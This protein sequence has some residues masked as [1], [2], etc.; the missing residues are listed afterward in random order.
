MGKLFINIISDY[1]VVGF[2]RVMFMV[3]RFLM[4]R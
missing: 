2:Y 1:Y 3:L 4:L